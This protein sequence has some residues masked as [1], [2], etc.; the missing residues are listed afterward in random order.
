MGHLKDGYAGLC[1]ISGNSD[2]LNIQ[3]VEGFTSFAALS[4]GEV[5]ECGV[6]PLVGFGEVG[7]YTKGTS[8]GLPKL[9]RT[10]V[11]RQRD[12]SATA[13]NWDTDTPVLIH[14]GLS[15][16]DVATLTGINVYEADQRYRG[17]KLVTS[18]D[19]LSWIYS[20]A[21]GQVDVVLANALA[22]SLSRGSFGEPLLTL[23]WLDSG[24]NPGPGINFFKD[25]ASP[26][27]GK[28]LG[29]MSF[30]S[31][32]SAGAIKA[33][34]NLVAVVGSPASGSEYGELVFSA[35]R[36]GSLAAALQLT[37][38]YVKV[39]P[40]LGDAATALL[41]G[42]TA[43]GIGN[44]G[45]ELVAT[46]QIA[47]TA[48]GI[49]PIVVN[50]KSSAGQIMQVQR[51]GG[52]VGDL[53]VDGAGSFTITGA[54][55]SHASEWADGGPDPSELVGTVVCS[56]E[57]ALQDGAGRHPLCRISTMPADPTVY[58][59]LQAR[60]DERLHGAKTNRRVRH[61]KIAGAGAGVARTVGPVAAGDLLETSELPGVARRQ[62]G[63]AIRASTLGKARETIAGDGEVRLIRT[64]LLAG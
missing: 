56:T 2:Y 29:A 60:V 36:N 23:T 40:G 21:N 4:N 12:R 51:D 16:E 27:V 13:V 5:I 43:Q 11:F 52:F 63:D 26:A 25:V 45:I 31:R 14:S 19:D 50:R 10:R 57:G 33:F 8:G 1:T 54:L 59:V 9:A 28:A 46:G 41:V 44:I 58:G 39:F 42:K 22:A 47:A 6:R 34:A 15:A 35:M 24:A 17:N 30:L 53:T 55:L 20:S 18:A 61:L 3:D 64:T 62:A 37:G 32:N 48:D 49:P 7:K 38:N